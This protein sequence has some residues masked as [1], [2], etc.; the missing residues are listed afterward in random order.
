MDNKNSIEYNGN[1][2]GRKIRQ[3]RGELSLRNFAEKCGISHTHLDSIEKGYDPRTGKHVSIS[4]ETI[5]KLSQ[6]TGIPE[7]NLII[8]ALG[9]IE[10]DNPSAMREIEARFGEIMNDSDEESES[11][12]LLKAYLTKQGFTNFSDDELEDF[13]DTIDDMALARGFLEGG[14]HD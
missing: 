14:E 12:Q 5:S 9:D 3:Y 8:L 1:H 2:L 13:A 11:L 7:R 10:H 4:I 6:G